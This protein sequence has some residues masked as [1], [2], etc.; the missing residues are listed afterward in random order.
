MSYVIGIDS[1][2]THITATA[3]KNNL[4][5][6]T[7]TTGPGNI[8]LNPSQTIENLTKVISNISKK[9]SSEKCERILIGIAGLESADNPQPYLDKIKDYFNSLTKNII[10]ISD[11]K[12]A[13]VNGLEGKDGFLA[14]AGTGSIVY[15]K[16]QN[17]FLRAGGWGYLLDDIGSGYRISQE[18]V[19][20]ALEKMDRGENSS[21]TSAIL[22]YF[23]VDNLKNVVSK[24]Y[25]LNRTEIAAF[26]LK[27]AQAA[28]QKNSEAIEVLQHQASLL[29]DEIIHLIKRYPQEEVSLN[30]ALSGSVLINN[31]IIQKEIKSIVKQTY[32]TINITVTK[33]SNTA[34]VN[35]I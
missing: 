20:T 25:K 28:N 12:L 23:K 34:A 1:G 17:K 22:E 27:I 10:F 26:S 9:L 29:A 13:L 30:L 35:Y 19:T 4:E 33:R 14:I 31:E 11:A 15:G 5:L 16:Q 32:P 18:A 7:T 6:I 8:F 2:G 21:L 3:Y 24:Y